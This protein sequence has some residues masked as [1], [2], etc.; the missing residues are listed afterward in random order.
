[1]VNLLGVHHIDSEAF[2]TV[3]DEYLALEISAEDLLKPIDEATKLWM[4]NLVKAGQD[5][6]T[7]LLT[8]Q[9]GEGITT[10]VLNILTKDT[11]DSITNYLESVAPDSGQLE[12]WTTAW[13]ALSSDV[14]QST[15]TIKEAFS[16]EEISG[17]LE[18]LLGRAPTDAEIEEWRTKYDDIGR[19]F[20]YC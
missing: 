6:M 11:Q 19:N 4:N 16:D 13:T 14:T 10:V 18:T 1:M 3:L 8:G 20:R 12:T 2:K 7:Q 15:K 9:T 5:W 17:F